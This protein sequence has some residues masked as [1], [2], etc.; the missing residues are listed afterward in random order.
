MTVLEFICAQA[1]YAMKGLLIGIWYSALSI[2]YLVV[3]ILDVYMIEENS[4]NIYHGVKGFGI[5]LSIVSFSL[6]C[7]FYHYRERDEI[8]NEQ[9]VIEI[10]YERELLY[11]REEEEELESEEDELTQLRNYSKNP[12][13][14][15]N[16]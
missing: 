16:Y 1:P 9:A 2:K 7:K 14:E 13:T 6:V 15:L 8:V 12:S 4:W 11:N 3:G 10:Q 5:F